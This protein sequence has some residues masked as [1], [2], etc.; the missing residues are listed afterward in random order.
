MLIAVNKYTGRTVMV[1]L[2]NVS[3]TV[4]PRIRPGSSPGSIYP[5]KLKSLDFNPLLILI[6]VIMDY[7]IN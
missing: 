6:W 1:S 3:S 2:G 4:F 7:E 5:S